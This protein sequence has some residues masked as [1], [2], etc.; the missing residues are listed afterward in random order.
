MTK[1]IVTMAEVA[2]QNGFLK[3]RGSW[4]SLTKRAV[5]SITASL[6]MMETILESP[7][8]D[9]KLKASTANQLAQLSMGILEADNRDSISRM[10]AQVKYGGSLLGGSTA[11]D[12]SD[13]PLIDFSTIREP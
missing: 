4:S 11:D 1:K 12:D 9:E 13:I 6:D 3:K 8:A 7:T 2:E 10:L 5:K